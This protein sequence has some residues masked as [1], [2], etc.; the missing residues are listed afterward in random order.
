[1]PYSQDKRT[2]FLTIAVVFLAL[3]AGAIGG[4]FIQNFVSSEA[5]NF[6]YAL[7]RVV[8]RQPS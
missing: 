3:L 4:I 8:W 7:E 2:L 6:S 1:M 5:G